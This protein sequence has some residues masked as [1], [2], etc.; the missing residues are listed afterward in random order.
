MCTIPLI[1]ETLEKSKLNCSDKADE[2]WLKVSMGF[3]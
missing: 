2:W 1:Y 3:A